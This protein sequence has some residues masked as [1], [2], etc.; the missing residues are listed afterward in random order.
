MNNSREA[1]PSQHWE[2]TESYE[3]TRLDAF[4]QARLPGMA[5]REILE[6]IA[7]ARV[8]INDRRGKKGDRLHQG[9]QVRLTAAAALTANPRLAIPVRFVDEALLILDKPAGIPSIALRHEETNT[10]PNFLLAYFP[11]TATASPRP[12]EAGVVHRLDT[13]TSGLL[14]VARTPVIHTILRHAFHS[15]AVEK[16]YLA[17]VEGHVRA[18]GQ[19]ASWLT[20]EGP[21]GQR[22]REDAGGRGQWAITNYIPLVALPSHTLLRVTIATGVRHQ[23]RMQLAAL[24][25]P[26][27]GDILYGSTAPGTRLCLHATELTFTHPLTGK[28]VRCRSPLPEDFQA[29][30]KQLGA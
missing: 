2:V 19:R 17:L 30:R 24:G 22:M 5:K 4:L 29:V 10:V 23:I 12:L 3:A 6:W 9:D 11:D 28:R 21:R 18:S 20:P 27:V 16:Q 8:H 13:A 1:A 26:I 14:V 25:H 7:A 15:H